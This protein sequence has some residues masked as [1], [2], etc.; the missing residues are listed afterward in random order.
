MEMEMMPYVLPPKERRRDI[1]ALPLDIGF[2]DGDQVL[3]FDPGLLRNRG[4]PLRVLQGLPQ[5]GEG[6]VPVLLQLRELMVDP[7]LQGGPARDEVGILDPLF[8][9]FEGDPIVDV[10]GHEGWIHWAFISSFLLS[11]AR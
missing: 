1:P 9:V 2:T 6:S 4:D 7:L 5:I 8:E 3:L 10:I 11:N